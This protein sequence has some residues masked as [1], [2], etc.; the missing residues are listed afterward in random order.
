[1]QHTVTETEDTLQVD[2]QFILPK[3]EVSVDDYP[4][5]YQLVQAASDNSSYYAYERQD[6][7]ATADISSEPIGAQIDQVKVLLDTAQFES[8]LNKLKIIVGNHG[9]HAEAHFLLGL[10]YGFNG[11][12]E[13]SEKAFSRA[14][15]LGYE[16]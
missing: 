12:D 8:A 11:Q 6:N 3:Q 4:E 13:L 10:A 2:T 7:S 14:M 16:L 5:F 15:E 1:M 9:G